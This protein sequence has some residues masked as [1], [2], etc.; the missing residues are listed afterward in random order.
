MKFTNIDADTIANRP[1]RLLLEPESARDREQLEKTLRACV[2]A[3]CGRDPQTGLI[4][5]VLIELEPRPSR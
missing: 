3:G 1:P 5:H 4:E 2:S